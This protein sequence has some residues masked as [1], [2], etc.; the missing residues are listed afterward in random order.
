L[1]NLNVN[2]VIERYLHDDQPLVTPA[3]VRLAPVAG[4]DTTAPPSEGASPI[5]ARS[6]GAE[7]RRIFDD[8][9]T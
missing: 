6:A 3:A 9:A 7:P 5:P 8:E 2:T 1:R 4:H